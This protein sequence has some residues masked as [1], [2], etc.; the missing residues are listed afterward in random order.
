MGS[1]CSDIDVGRFS[2]GG[3][4]AASTALREPPDCALGGVIEM[5]GGGVGMDLPPAT[6][7]PPL[8]GS[9]R[10]SGA[11]ATAGDLHRGTPGDFRCKRHEG[12]QIST[13]YYCSASDSSALPW[14]RPLQDAPTRRKGRAKLRARLALKRGV[15]AQP[16]RRA[17]KTADPPR[18]SATRPQTRS[19]AQLVRAPQGKTLERHTPTAD[20]LTQHS[21]QEQTLSIAPHNRTARMPQRD[22]S[23]PTERSMPRRRR[24]S[25]R[26]RHRWVTQR[27]AL[28]P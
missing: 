16:L 9:S 15:R 28:Q 26:R 6:G 21:T 2:Q 27:R 5:S 17:W 7:F 11:C 19:A 24:P 23:T 10:G 12:L 18:Q 3:W 14:P 20:A 13:H 22:R 4:F 25:T 1:A 8:R